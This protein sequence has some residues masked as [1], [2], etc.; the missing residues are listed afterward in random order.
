MNVRGSAIAIGEGAVVPLMVHRERHRVVVLAMSI[1]EILETL[2]DAI[3]VA[4][5]KKMEETSD[6]LLGGTRTR[7][8]APR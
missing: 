6:I 5:L 3:D 4:A 8:G 7:E 1:L 2:V